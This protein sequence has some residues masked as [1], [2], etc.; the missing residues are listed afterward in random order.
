MGILESV[1]PPPPSSCKPTTYSGLNSTPNRGSDPSIKSKLNK[2]FKSPGPAKIVSISNRHPQNMAQSSPIASSS[3]LAPTNH[4]RRQSNPPTHT[5]RESNGDDAEWDD[6]ED[7]EDEAAGGEMPMDVER[8]EEEESDYESDL[9]DQQITIAVH[10]KLSPLQSLR[11]NSRTDE[12]SGSSYE[13]FQCSYALDSP[14]E[15]PRL[16]KTAIIIHHWTR[17]GMARIDL[18]GPEPRFSHRHGYMYVL[19]RVSSSYFSRKVLMR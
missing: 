12:R 13:T 9:E 1:A 15:P 19:W 3:R 17:R 2:P 11:G 5:R 4:A 8:S 16:P 7:V 18:S 14:C 6:E 10:G